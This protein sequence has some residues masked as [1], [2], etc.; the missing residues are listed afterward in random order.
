MTVARAESFGYAQ[1]SPIEKF[2][3]ATGRSPLF[4]IIPT[5]RRGNAG[6]DAPALC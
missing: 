4:I 1:E 5:L 3:G 6:C 2:V